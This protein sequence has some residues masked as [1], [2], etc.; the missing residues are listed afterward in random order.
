MNKY[1]K[2]DKIRNNTNMT[3]NDKQQLDT[4]QIRNKITK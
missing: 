4:K 3:F 1:E 2:H